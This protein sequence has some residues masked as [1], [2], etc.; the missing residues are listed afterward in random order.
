M[1]AIFGRTSPLMFPTVP[2]T[3]ETANSGVS[4]KRF[5]N[6]DRFSSVGFSKTMHNVGH[7]SK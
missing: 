5:G 6:V 2:C 7:F 1:K 3:A 4:P